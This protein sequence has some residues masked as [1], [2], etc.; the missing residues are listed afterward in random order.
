MKYL[1]TPRQIE[2]K[3]VDYDLSDDV[4]SLEAEQKFLFPAVVLI[5]SMFLCAV[6]MFGCNVA[7]AELVVDM[8]KIAMIESSGCKNLVGDGGLALGCYQIHKSVVDDF[9]KYN[10]DNE[11]FYSHNDMLNSLYAYVVADWYMNNRIPQMLRHYKKP[12][13]LENRL[14]AYNMGIG[15][16]VKG[17][18][19]TK[20]INKYKG[21]K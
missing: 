11:D 6:I 2:L 4:Y 12:D 20:Y 7:S 15:S 3:P 16:V 17:K 8:N 13:T 18:V 5:V 19:A 1:R 10:P 14:T 9:N 21:M